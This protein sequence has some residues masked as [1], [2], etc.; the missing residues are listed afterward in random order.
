[1]V[2]ILR[3]MYQVP[4]LAI[5]ELGE[6]THI[7]TGTVIVTSVARDIRGEALKRKEDALLDLGE[8]CSS[9]SSSIPPSSPDRVPRAWTPTLSGR[10]NA[11]SDSDTRWLRRV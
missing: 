1:M 6:L 9:P 8:H 11:S 10:V 7:A 3:G 5:G 4:R 2:K